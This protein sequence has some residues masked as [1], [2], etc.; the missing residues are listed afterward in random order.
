MVRFDKIIYM[1]TC[2]KSLV[3]DLE[4]SK[5]SL[6]N[7]NILIDENIL[8][9]ISRVGVTE[10]SF[11]LR[12]SH[13]ILLEAIP[14][15]RELFFLSQTKKHSTEVCKEV[16][17]FCNICQMSDHCDFCNKKNSWAYKENA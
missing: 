9:V 8:R 10:S 7:E 11:N 16:D 15:G 12:K 2:F 1:I 13:N 5:Y 14:L 4:Q 3:G 6:A 17:P